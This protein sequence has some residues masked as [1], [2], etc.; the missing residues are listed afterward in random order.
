[1]CSR[2]VIH[3]EDFGITNAQ[4]LLDKYADEIPCFND[5]I[6]GTGAV[7]LSALMA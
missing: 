2:A 1:M 4:R 6:Q 3:F 5:D 7:T